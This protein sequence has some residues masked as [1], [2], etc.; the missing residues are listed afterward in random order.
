MSL[1]TLCDKDGTLTDDYWALKKK[2][3]LSVSPQCVHHIY[4]TEKRLEGK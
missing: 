3:N 1:E 4:D 2:K